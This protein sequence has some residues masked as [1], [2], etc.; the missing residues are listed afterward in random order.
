VT[1]P[2]RDGSNAERCAWLSGISP[3]DV[4]LDCGIRAAT[5]A[6]ALGVARSTVHKWETGALRPYGPAGVAYCR[7]IA[8]LMRHLAVPEEALSPG[9]SHDFL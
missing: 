6:E 3:R 8:G 5:V 9:D 1:V 4:R 2:L 7:I